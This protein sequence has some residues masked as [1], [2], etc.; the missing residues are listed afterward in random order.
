MDK[1]FTAPSYWLLLHLHLL[2]LY[3]LANPAIYSLL[4]AHFFIFFFFSS[5]SCCWIMLYFFSLFRNQVPFFLSVGTWDG[6]C[7]CCCL[8]FHAAD[9]AL[10]WRVH[11]M[12]Q[13]SH[14]ALH[15]IASH[16]IRLWGDC[17]SPAAAHG[18]LLIS[19]I[20]QNTADKW[21]DTSKSNSEWKATLS[22]FSLLF[23]IIGI[24]GHKMATFST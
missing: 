14:V 7:C 15:R 17:I 19:V 3:A 5:D 18:F 21:T 13:E 16:L 12:P 10:A 11:S 20:H 22:L 23:Y 9:S 4:T 8:A 24:S 1:F 6:V 2:L